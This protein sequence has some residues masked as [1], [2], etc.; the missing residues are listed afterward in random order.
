MP[1]GKLVG[2]SPVTRAQTRQRRTHSIPDV[3]AAT[4]TFLGRRAIDVIYIHVSS[5]VRKDVSSLYGFTPELTLRE[6]MRRSPLPPIKSAEMFH[7]LNLFFTFLSTNICSKYEQREFFF[8]FFP[9]PEG[10]FRI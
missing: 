1:R 2:G 10:S 8:F 7:L 6:R 5:K 4:V 3:G 9:S